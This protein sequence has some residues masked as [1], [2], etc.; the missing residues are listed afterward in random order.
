ME[1]NM[2]DKIDELN[3]RINELTNRNSYI[4]HKYEA[5]KTKLLNFK[6]TLEDIVDNTPIPEVNCSC[7][8]C[9][10]CYDC[11][12]NGATRENI[13]KIKQFIKFIE[14]INRD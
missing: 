9:P 3:N 7:H 8:I 13:E 12:E 11:V 5:L 6:N 4:N 14:I 10:P 1:E 2:N